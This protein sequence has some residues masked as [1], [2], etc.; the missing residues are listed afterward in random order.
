V[1]AAGD[2]QRDFFVS[3]TG[4]D[5]AWAEW[6]AWQLE[7]DGWTTVLQAWDFHPGDNFVERMRDALEQA[8]R[9]IA[10][11]SPAYLASPYASDEWT[12]AFLHDK[13]R[14]GRLLP[15][16]IEKCDPPRLLATRVYVD[17]VGL[18]RQAAR[19]RLLEGVKRGRRRPTRA[20][21]FPGGRTAVPGQAEGEPRF[22]AQGPAVTNLPARNPNFTGR[23]EL[24]E[25]LRASLRGKPGVV[26]SQTGAIHGLGGVGKTELAL[27]FAHRYQA[28]Y[29]LVWWISAEQ[30]TSVTAD[31]AALAEELGIQRAADQAEMVNLLF[32]ELRGQERWLLVYDNAERPGALEGLLPP[33]GGGRVL[34][35]SRYGAWGRLG[36]SLRLDVLARDEAVALLGRRTGATDQAVLGALASELGDLPLALEEAAAYLEETHTDLGEYLELVRERARELFSLDKSADDADEY[37]DQRR[38]AT[39]WSLSLQRVH[40]E[41]PAAET[42]LD[43]CAF[44]APGDIPRELP[45][46]HAE[47]LPDQLAEGVGDVVAYN[48]L[49]GAVGRYSLATVTPTSLG[50]HRLVQAVLQARLGP[51]GER[52]WATAAIGL[53]YESFPNESWEV[54]TWQ[55]CGRL[56]PHVLAACGHGQRLGVAGAPA[57]WLLDRASMYPRERGLYRQARPVA[58]RALAVTEAA[59]GP[60]DVAVGSCW[61]ELGSV[62]RELGDLAAARVQSQRAL[63]I[64]ETA[65]GLNHPNVAT[66]SGNL[67]HVLREL[68]DLAGARAQLERAL[69]ISGT[70]LG[71]DHPNVGIDRGN[72][73][74][75]LQALGDLAGA[76]A[77]V[78]RA[79]EI[80]EAALGPDHPHVVVGR[81]I[82]GSVLQDLG[83]LAGAKE[84]YEQA[85]AIG[86]ATLGPDHPEVAVWRSNLGVVLQALGDLAGAQA[87]LERALAIGEAALGPDHPDVV[88][89]RDNLSGVLQAPQDATAEGPASAV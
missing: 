12:G 88:T 74:K 60:E 16:R 2:Q 54:A 63:A 83:D 72:L 32:N 70:A 43:L 23:S 17:L 28:D 86:E 81:S 10:L 41:A 64:G 89:I 26:V 79:L 27:E 66:W 19:T 18:G 4:A 77:Q 82:L 37:G 44:L 39:V 84:Q 14:E 11:L 61:D 34:V 57:G 55:R 6:I 33:G 24:L 21:A 7:D 42:L 45:R 62:L 25:Q 53:L 49:L 69:V 58:E 67:G 36:D 78:E 22:P 30:P 80:H 50:V 52:A 76:K 87:Q 20:P 8:D 38:V 3:Y 56:L 85:V 73:A 31:L 5:R 47:V 13:D 68:G 35:T 51:D 46:E 71:P 40:Q 65:L 29:D 59:L 48:R 75:V 15:V 1:T 9:T